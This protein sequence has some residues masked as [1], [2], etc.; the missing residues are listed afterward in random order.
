MAN[1]VFSLTSDKSTLPDDGSLYATLSATIHDD[2][3]AAASGV[4]V[5][6]AISAGTGKLDV[7]TSTTDVTGV[8][9]AKITASAA[10][11]LSVKATTA[12]DTTGKTISIYAGLPLP[13]PVITG[14]SYEDNYTLDYYDL[15]LGVQLTIPFYPN[16]KAG[17]TVTFF[18]GDV[19][20]H[21]FTLSD[22]S[23]QLPYVVDVTTE[24][25]PDCLIDGEYQVYYSVTDS[26][27]NA[28]YSSGVALTI[29]NGGQTTPTLN[30]PVV[31]V[32]A[33][34][35]INIADA[36]NGVEVDVAYT[37]MAAGDVITLYWSAKDKNGNPVQT[38]TTMQQYTVVTGETSHAFMLDA[39]L[40]F[41]N[42]GQ[43]YEGSVDAYYTV[44]PVDSSA[45]ELSFTQTVQVDTVAPGMHG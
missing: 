31:P 23:Q 37:G 40:F 11:L 24:C 30:K 1:T 10:G 22:P 3:G 5:T 38:A 28:S 39:T 43:G 36:A 2:A 34:G 13:A 6:W 29:R 17:D 14:A 44:M 32:A 9:T 27:G 21:S 25:P 4:A 8:A 42:N 15:Q 7:T 26:A 41:P 45:I 18:W 16:A 19:Y 20:S 35:F 12:D 33:D